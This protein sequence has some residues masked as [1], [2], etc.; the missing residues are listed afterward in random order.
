MVKSST[1]FASDPLIIPIKTAIISKDKATFFVLNTWHVCNVLVSRICNGY[2][3]L[4]TGQPKLPRSLFK[5]RAFSPWQ[6][7]PM[8][9]GES[10]KIRLATDLP[11]Y[12]HLISVILKDYNS[13]D[14]EKQWTMVRLIIVVI[15][16]MKWSLP[17]D[18]MKVI[19]K[20]PCLRCS[21][22]RLVES[23][24]FVPSVHPSLAKP[25]KSRLL[26]LTNLPLIFTD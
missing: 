14:D 13:T 12:S 3:S 7:Q 17:T 20:H 10:G 26:M 21:S 9:A 1:K 4:E 19:G 23:E 15:Y 22:S 11:S 5:P 2:L 24:M 6:Q 18:S 25:R 16:P 8:A